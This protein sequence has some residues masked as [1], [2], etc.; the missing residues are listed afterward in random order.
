[1]YKGE[2]ILYVLFMINF[3]EAFLLNAFLFGASFI[4]IFITLLLVPRACENYSRILLGKPLKSGWY[5]VPFSLLSLVG[6][7]SVV[8]SFLEIAPGG[9]LLLSSFLL[10]IILKIYIEK[11]GRLLAIKAK[12]KENV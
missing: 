3:Q 2:R 5:I 6:I 11:K 12:I 9:Y 10:M 7:N 4:L 8:L 1:M